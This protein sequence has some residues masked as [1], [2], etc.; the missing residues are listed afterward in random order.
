MEKVD[1]LNRTKPSDWKI[2]GRLLSYIVP[3]LPLF[4]ISILTYYNTPIV[5][6][7]NK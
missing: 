6:T 5:I 7:I 4:F 2:Y 1:S 3:Y